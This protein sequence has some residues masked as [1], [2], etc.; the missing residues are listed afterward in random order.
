LAL[1]FIGFAGIV[2]WGAERP[3]MTAFAPEV[4]GQ[5]ILSFLVSFETDLPIFVRV[6]R[7]VYV[8]MGVCVDGSTY[9]IIDRVIYLA[10]D[11]RGSFGYFD[12]A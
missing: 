4:L 9:M 12:Q 8:K 1:F 10:M 7:C 2:G 3:S 6:R 5:V 11:Q